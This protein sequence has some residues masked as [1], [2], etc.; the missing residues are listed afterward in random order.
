M[1]QQQQIQNNN[2][3]NNYSSHEDSTS[4]TLSTSSTLSSIHSNNPM[5]KITIN[6]LDEKDNHDDPKWEIIAHKAR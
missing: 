2:N 6:K 3:N 1:I 5:L 4:L